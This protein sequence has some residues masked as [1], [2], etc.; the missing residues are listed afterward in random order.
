MS[1]PRRDIW[2]KLGHVG[3]MLDLNVAEGVGFEPTI[4]FP[5]YT[6]SKRAPSATRPSL[7]DAARHSASARFCGGRTIVAGVGLRKPLSSLSCVVLQPL[8]W[9]FGGRRWRVGHCQKAC[10]WST[11]PAGNTAVGSNDGRR[12][13]QAR[14]RHEFRCGGLVGRDARVRPAVGELGLV[15]GPEQRLHTG[16]FDQWLHGPHRVGHAIPAKHAR[17]LQQPRHRLS[18]QRRSRSRHRRL[19][20]SDQARSQLRCRLPESRPF[21]LCQA[22]L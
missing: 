6:L 20:R 2:R 17:R 5:V 22:R 3:T 11:M 10:G 13:G 16:H 21:L 12:R 15:R 18:R 19:H 8:S 4:R 1:L 9:G 14:H 7:R